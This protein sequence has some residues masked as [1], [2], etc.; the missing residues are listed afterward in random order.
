MWFPETQ[1]NLIH[2]AGRVWSPATESALG[3]LCVAYRGSLVTFATMLGHRPEDAEDLTQ[4]FLCKLLKRRTLGRL[5]KSRGRF[6]SYLCKAFRNFIHSVWAREAAKKRGGP[7]KEPVSLDLL[8]PKIPDQLQVHPEP[9]ERLFDRHWAKLIFERAFN[10]LEHEYIRAAK[11]TL[12]QELKFLM[13]QTPSKILRDTVADRLGITI[14]S[15]DVH[16]H[17]VRTRYREICR[18]LIQATVPNSS[19]VEDEYQY[20]VSFREEFSF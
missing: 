17:R 11:A 6:R 8:P 10:Q 13:T 2:K 14:N 5:S 20:L 18:E 19:H 7:K 9:A 4:S 12:F 1:W 3:D 16:L 15:L